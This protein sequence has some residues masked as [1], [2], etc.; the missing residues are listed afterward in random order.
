MLPILLRDSV[1]SVKIIAV[2]YRGPGLCRRRGTMPAGICS[3]IYQFIDPIVCEKK[4][5]QTMGEAVGEDGGS[6]RVFSPAQLIIQ[7]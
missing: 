6:H 5:F 2:R 7:V 4:K 3:F 1:T